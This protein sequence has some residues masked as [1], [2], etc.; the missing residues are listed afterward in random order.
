MGGVIGQGNLLA[1][2][3]R[4]PCAEG[5]RR[6]KLEAIP[7]P[8]TGAVPFAE[9]A[10]GADHGRAEG[11]ERGGDKGEGWQVQG[12]DRSQRSRGYPIQMKINLT[13]NMSNN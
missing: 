11:D 8:E 2:G 5:D 12:T 7:G 6:E 4:G 3:G 9:Q 13:A 10:G 1:R